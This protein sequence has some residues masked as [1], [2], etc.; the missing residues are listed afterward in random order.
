MEQK[1]KKTVT[2]LVFLTVLLASAAAGTGILSDQGPG[3]YEYESI[4]GETVLI[5]GKGLY[6]HMSADVAVQGIAQDYITLFAGIP[7]LLISLYFAGKGS[8][9]GLYLLAGTAGYFFVTY[10]FYTVM[11]MYNIMFLPYVMLLCLSFFTL[12]NTLLSFPLAGL[13]ARFCAKTPVKASGSFLF[14]NAFL[15]SLMW[16]GVVVPPLTDRSIIPIAVEHYTTLVVQG[17]DLGLLLPL[18]FVSAVLFLKRK[19]LGFLL[20]PV[21]LVFLSIL[22]TALS[23]KIAAMALTGVNIFPAVIIIP[24]INLL[25]VVFAFRLIKSVK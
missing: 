3:Q 18:G 21:Y 23:A 16:L 15:V 12:A 22:M 6:R 20:T 19:P 24:L 10:L 11:G 25:S 13:P 17:L 9:K 8:L 14:I 1:R 4:R 5:Y 2:I 7:M